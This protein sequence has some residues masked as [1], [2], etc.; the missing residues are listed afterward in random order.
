MTF[1]TTTT[2]VASG[3]V[4]G[5]ILPGGILPAQP[6]DFGS[7]GTVPSG[8]APSG[9]VLHVT[10]PNLKYFS[11]FFESSFPLQADSVVDS[12]T[13]DNSDGRKHGSGE[14]RVDLVQQRLYLRSQAKNVSAGIKEVESRVLFR[15]DTGILY[16]RTKMQGFSQ[17]LA[18]N[19]DQVSLPGATQNPFM[20]ARQVGDGFQVAST[21][22]QKYAL[23]VADK[24]RLQMFVGKDNQL[25]ALE[26]DDMKNAVSLGVKVS[27]WVTD[28]INDAWFSPGS[29]WNCKDPQT[30]DD[31]QSLMNWDLFMFLFGPKFAPEQ[32]IQKRVL[33]E[34]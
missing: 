14:L 16:S 30:L 20:T 10:D 32:G 18:V 19:I 4:P 24:S 7:D 13:S 25:L 27:D 15:G 9:P 12:I 2:T 28:P 26:F 23:D 6:S 34:M 1:E 33:A 31:P 5:G 11:F 8:T 3:F 22:S 17:C 21:T 29:D